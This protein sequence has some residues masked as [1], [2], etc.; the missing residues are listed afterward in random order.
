M[1]PLGPPEPAD[2]IGMKTL[3]Q[4][5]I[6]LLAAFIFPL[7]TSL[8]ESVIDN[9]S[10][11]V[12]NLPVDRTPDGQ[13]KLTPPSLIRRSP[14]RIVASCK[15]EGYQ[16]QVIKENGQKKSVI[17]QLLNGEESTRVIP[18]VVTQKLTKDMLGQYAAAVVVAQ[19]LGLTEVDYV[20]I[21]LVDP[22]QD[23]KSSKALVFFYDSD[24]DIIERTLI[25]GDQWERCLEE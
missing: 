25:S 12:I 15:L 4:K 18:F 20:K 9:P 24:D 19:E 2:S 17:K 14:P 11:R 10:K 22:R 16:A 1:A 5:T 7:S 6:V 21:M 23:I 3:L 13:W 8:A